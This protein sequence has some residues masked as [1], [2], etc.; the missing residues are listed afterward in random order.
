MASI[1]TTTTS[2][3]SSASASG[4]RPINLS[5]DLA[6]LADLIEIV[7]ADTMD[8][9]GRAA[10]REMRMLS[11]LGRGVN[12]LQKLSDSTLGIQ[13][14]Y[15]WIEDGKLVGN[16]SIYPAKIP[17]TNRVWI[18]ANVGTHPDYQRRGIARELMRASLEDIRARGG[19]AAVLQVDYDN[20]KAQNL[21]L[22]L[23]FR[24]ERAWT[25]WRRPTN[26][27]T[28]PPAEIDTVYIT[29]PR[30]NEWRAIYALA[31]QLYPDS[32]GGLGWLRP[33][34]PHYFRTGLWQKLQDALSLRSR[35]QLVI[36]SSDEREIHAALLIER[37]AGLS[38]RLSLMVAPQYVTLY[39]EALIS[40][41]VRRFGNES[42]VL[43]YPYEEQ[44]TASIL[45]RYHFRRSRSA[46]HMRL[47]FS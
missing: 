10:L 36:R 12:L 7:F 24:I 18:I 43:E 39:D 28:P 32:L 25:V 42:M 2:S 30:R 40:T 11:K 23:G 8:S 38:T 6:P 37:N 16:V 5:T 15:V 41:A 13:Q 33:V 34:T 44:L 3:T 35:E 9:G 46:Y 31:Q 29:H 47:D 1:T 27:R 45:E 19:R 26:F 14:G 17:G 20:Y 4:M 22:D 21:Y